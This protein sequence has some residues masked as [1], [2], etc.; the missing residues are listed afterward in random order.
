MDNK[1][2]LA[3]IIKTISFITAFIAGL[4]V[5]ISNLKI[6]TNSKIV[7]QTKEYILMFWSD[8]LI[9]VIFLLFVSFT[10]KISNGIYAI[11]KAKD[12][13]KSRPMIITC[14]LSIG[15]LILSY[16]AYYQFL[17]Y[18]RGMTIRMNIY[19][20]QLISKANAL[21]NQGEI[22]EAAATL[23]RC[24]EI[25]DSYKC[26]EGLGDEEEL[27]QALDTAVWIYG[28]T[29]CNSPYKQ[30]VLKIIQKLEGNKIISI[31]L[32]I[33]LTNKIRKLNQTFR[34]GI[35]AIKNHEYKL[36]HK[37]FSQLNEEE[38]GYMNSHLFADELVKIIRS[39]GMED[40]RIKN[41]TYVSAVLRSNSLDSIVDQLNIY[42]Y[43]N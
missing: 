29:P 17:Y 13:Y 8:M 30:T 43:A 14:A 33:S 39:P 2:S 40:K 18:E 4:A 6:I 34:E 1:S 42:D 9:I 12:Y 38:P 23:K 5:L 10:I 28:I 37:H 7:L 41:T 25:F 32:Q 11:I 3:Y 21:H 20:N 22:S 16:N 19:K 31:D 27:L 26:K 36:A 35:L 24:Y 15:I